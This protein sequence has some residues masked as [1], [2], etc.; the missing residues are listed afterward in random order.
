[1]CLSVCLCVCLC[2]CAC[3]CVRACVSVCG[4]AAQKRALESN[5]PLD[6][7]HFHRKHGNGYRVNLL[8]KRIRGN[9]QKNIFFSYS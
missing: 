9:M 5:R 2:L 8:L 7:R 6:V 1:V 3:V 4:G